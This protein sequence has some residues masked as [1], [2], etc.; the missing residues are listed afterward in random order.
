M[1]NNSIETAETI[2]TLEAQLQNAGIDTSKWGTGNTKTLE[3]LLNEIL[4]GE[5][6]LVQ[7]ETGELVRQVVIVVADIY[8]DNPNG[9]RL[10]LKENRQVFADGRERVRD[11]LPQSVSEKI[12]PNEDSREAIIRGIREELGI[13]IDETDAKFVSTE[14]KTLDSPSCPG[15]MSEYISHKFQITL[16]DSHYKPEG[17]VEVQ[18]D[19]STYFVWE[20]EKV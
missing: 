17:Y 12:K 8:Y 11:H 20:E 5:V 3:H 18:N 10:H 2:E 16:N 9:K 4:C 13:A 15:L 6:T 14:S 19:K 7:Q 1:A